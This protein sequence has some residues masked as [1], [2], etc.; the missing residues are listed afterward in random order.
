VKDVFNN[1]AKLSGPIILELKLGAIATTA[2][3]ITVSI[4]TL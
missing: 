3:I 4:A 1:F 2:Y